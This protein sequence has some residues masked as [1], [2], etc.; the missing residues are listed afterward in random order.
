MRPFSLVLCLV[1]PALAV[2]CQRGPDALPAE[3]PAGEARCDDGS[4]ELEADTQRATAKTEKAVRLAG[5]ATFEG[6]LAVGNTLEG[7]VTGGADKASQAWNKGKANVKSA[8]RS[9]ADEVRRADAKKCPERPAPAQPS[10][11]SPAPSQVP[12]APL[13]QPAPASPEPSP[14]A[15]LPVD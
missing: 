14:A 5:Q 3:T 9:R 7:L 2:G 13:A 1:T 4:S 11:V 6:A 15:P 8:S 12:A 10:A